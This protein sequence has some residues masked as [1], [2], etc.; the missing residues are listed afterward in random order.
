ME[1]YKLLSRYYDDI[2]KTNE[3][4]IS[5]IKDFLPPSGKLLDL[6]AGTGAEANEFVKGG[7]SVTATDYSHEMVNIINEKSA[8]LPEKMEVAVLDMRNVS[9]LAPAFF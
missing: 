5:F 2:F 1:F 8:Q 4:A 6:G 3:K 9:H 7:Y